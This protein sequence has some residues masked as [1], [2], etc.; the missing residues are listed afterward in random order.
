MKLIF[1]FI[2]LVFTFNAFGTETKPYRVYLK[3]GTIL[4]RLSDKQELKIEHGIYANIL[5]VSANRRDQ[6][7][8]YDKAGKPLYETS[9]EGIVEIANDIRLLPDVNA[10]ISYPPPSTMKANNKYAFFDT[11]F[12]IHFDLL[13]TSAFNNIYDQDLGNTIGNRYELR[14]F[15]NSELPVNFGLAMNYEALYWDNNFEKM[16]MTMFSLGPHFQHYIYEE[17]QMAISLIGGAEYAPVY[18]TVYT[19]ETSKNTDKYTAVLF[20]I[21]AEVLWDTRFGK[22]NLGGHY[23]RHDLTLNTSNRDDINPVPENIVINSIGVMV[24]YKYEWDL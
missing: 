5:E 12:N 8:V 20:D 1:V 15:Y 13:Q 21:G 9:A 10:E 11:Q 14:T 17:N 23:R 7:I 22:W 18:K 3:P 16:T 24:G 6:F 2:F 19:T 4:T